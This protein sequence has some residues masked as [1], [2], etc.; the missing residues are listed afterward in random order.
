MFYINYLII[1]IAFSV[2]ISYMQLLKWSEETTGDF[3]MVSH[4]S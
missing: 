2:L 4:R 1:A 3:S